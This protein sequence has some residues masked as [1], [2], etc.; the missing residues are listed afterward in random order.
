MVADDYDYP[1]AAFAEST[2]SQSELESEV[3]VA[4][5]VEVEAEPEIQTQTIEHQPESED[6]DIG[7]VIVLY[8][9]APRGEFIKGEQLLS[10][11]IA[12]DLHF[13]DMDIFHRLTPEQQILFSLADMMEPGSFEYEKMHEHRT[14]GVSLFIQLNLCVDPVQA[15]DDM[16]IC[17]HNLA[18]MLELQIC[19]HNRQLLNESVAASLR[20][21]AK[22]VRELKQETLQS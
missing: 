7:D 5:D 17:A 2:G 6:T 21:K 14:R 1:P 16:L 10:A 20:A 18:S 22:H 12:S 15:L 3:E 8:L 11:A 13:G 9:V 19:D 4:T